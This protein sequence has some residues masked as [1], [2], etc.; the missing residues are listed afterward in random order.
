MKK[1]I[2]MVSSCI[3]YFSQTGNTER[4]AYTIAGRLQGEGLENVTLQTEDAQDFPEAYGDADILG[5]GFPTFFGYPPPHI[6]RFIEGLDGAGKSAFVFTTYGGCTAGDS[7]YDAA[8]AL[9]GRGYRI[10]GGLK[11]EGADNYP[12]GLRL[13]INEGRLDDSDLAKAEEFAAMAVQAYKN[14][15]GLDPEALRST[16][17]F[18]IKHRNSPRKKTVAAMRRKVEGKIIFDKQQCLFC[19][20]CKRSCPTKSIGSGEAFPEF[21]WK[22]IDGM[23]CYQ[24]VRVCPGKALLC[25][26]PLTDAEYK[27]Y[28]RGVADSPEEK[29]RVYLVA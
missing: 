18:F 20:S 6:M 25:E 15:R 8:K 24:C 14:N 23:R 29:S 17:K 16:N 12:Q 2:T 5:L 3:L 4:V 19:E 9:A 11:V 26:Q 1:G 7:L 13:K 21:S 10:L 28:L 22:C 27:K